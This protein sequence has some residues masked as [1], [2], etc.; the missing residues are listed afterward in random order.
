[1][2]G[3]TW[4]DVTSNDYQYRDPRFDASGISG[5]FRNDRTQAASQ[6]SWHYHMFPS[7]SGLTSIPFTYTSI[8]QPIQLNGLT[9]HEVY[10]KSTGQ[11]VRTTPVGRVSKW[12]QN[13]V[14]QITQTQ[15]ASFDAV[16]FGHDTHGRLNGITQGTRSSTITYNTNGYVDTVTNA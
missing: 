4:A 9:T 15:R 11:T 5:F 13:S 1:K 16:N 10:T 3:E 2:I 12:T 8:D 14:G 6:S 7:I